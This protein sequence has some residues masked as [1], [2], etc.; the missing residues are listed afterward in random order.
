MKNRSVRRFAQRMRFERL[1]CRMMLAADFDFRM[2]D[3]NHEAD[4]LL[5]EVSI[6][7]HHDDA[8]ILPPALQQPSEAGGR[9]PF[10]DEPSAAAGAN[11]IALDAF[12]RDGQGNRITS[13]VIGERV[14]VQVNF[15]LENLPIDASHTIHF[16]VNGVRLDN[17]TQTFGA[18]DPVFNGFWWRVGWFATAGTHDVIVELDGLNSVIETNE[19]DNVFA[20]S[21]TAVQPVIPQKLIWPLEGSPF[22]E[23]GIGNYVDVDP[24]GATAD[25]R[26]GRISYNGHDAWDIGHRFFSVQDSG[27]DVVAAADGI[28]I[29]THDGEFDRHSETLTPAAAPNYVIVDHGSGWTTFYYHLRRDSVSVEV[30]DFVLAG[31]SLG[32]MGSSGNSTG[33][34]VH[35]GLQHYGF[36]VEPMYDPSNYL[37]PSLAT[38]DYALDHPA[39]LDSGITNYIPTPHLTERPSDV[40]EL[41]QQPSQI[42]RAWAF[43]AGIRQ[44]DLV[45]FVWRRPNGTIYLTNSLNASNDFGTALW[46]WGRVLPTTPALGTWQ[47]DF[48]INGT[49]V[50]QDTFEV[51]PTGRQ[52][53]RIEQGTDI[54]L[55]GRVTPIDFG[56]PVVSSAAPTQTFTVTN[57]GDR[58]L[59]LGAIEVPRGYTVTDGLPS[60]LAPGQSDDLIVALS[61]ATAGYYAGQIRI[62]SDDADESSYEFSVEGVVLSSAAAPHVLLGISERKTSEGIQI[63]GNLRRVNAGSGLTSPLVVDL[64]SSVLTAA[65]V[66]SSVTIPANEER[67]IFDIVPLQ[68]GANVLERLVEI[69]AIVASGGLPDAWNELLITEKTPP[70]VES[71]VFNNGELQRSS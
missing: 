46:W 38:I 37:D 23:T 25:Y 19:A 28:V 24:T 40:E 50:G 55:D 33:P 48:R 7:Q 65:T 69:H 6:P 59:G 53:I 47:I 5:G 57:H 34:H 29:E 4:G 42:V 60:S 31:D 58:T 27:I 26:G 13:P 17:G 22:V 39:L 61:T 52:E 63:V 30:G 21:F 41:Q 35:F 54:V 49:K 16:T 14:A 9:I 68:D 10:V 44:G 56:S 11:L 8:V 32:R 15:R 51:T 18:G 43:F 62:A 36:T 45:E 20:F 70:L 3:P 66:P 12:L 71:V 67:V 2:V 1:E 64:Y